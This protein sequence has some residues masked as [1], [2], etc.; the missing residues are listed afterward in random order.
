ME[1]GSKRGLGPEWRWPA[2]MMVGAI[3]VAWTMHLIDVVTPAGRQ[4]FAVVVDVM[5]SVGI[6]YLVFLVTR[7]AT[8]GLEAPL[9]TPEQTRELDL[10]ARPQP[11]D[12]AARWILITLVIALAAG[13]LLYR[14]MNGNYLHQTA[15]FFVGVPTVLAITLAMT[16][17]A[18][19]VTGLIVK[20]IT[21][22]MLLSGIVFV[23]GFVC[24]VMASP[25]FYLVGIAIG[26]PIDRARKKKRSEGRVYSVVALGL[27][28]MSLEGVTPMTTFPPNEVIVVTQ[29]VDA[30]PSEVLAAMAGVP[31]FDAPLPFYLRLGF[32]RPAGAYG[33]G[34][35]VGDTR[36]ILFG[37]ES[38]MEPMREGTH[39]HNSGS[40]KGELELEIVDR[41]P[42]R[43]VF[44]VTRDETAFTHWI[45][46]G[47]S[48]VEWQGAGD[49]KTI[50]T[51]TLRFTRRLSPAW[52]F[53][54]MQR[55]AGKLAAG[56]LIDSVATP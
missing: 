37:D 19:S 28:L 36:T 41:R 50:V 16:P 20:G 8:W 51:W 11:P 33:S 15:L 12:K 40:G 29:E 49:G 56:Y 5:G 46:W 3:S 18:K 4:P 55:Y 7:P 6:L 53:G 9:A 22:A 38:P 47:R 34:L 2:A 14:V 48:I 52:Y 35:D 25:L 21:L 24:I 13:A 31:R 17:R 32:P 26:V 43:I 1:K 44:D 10:Y 27:L 54:P 42:G 30:S 23:E 45:T 39:H